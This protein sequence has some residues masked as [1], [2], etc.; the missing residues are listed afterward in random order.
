MSY[1]TIIVG[2]FPVTDTPEDVEVVSYKW[3][4]HQPYERIQLEKQYHKLKLPDKKKTTI[5][6]ALSLLERR[7]HEVKILNEILAY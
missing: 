3:W 2:H 6:K 5:V 1:R 4:N 7:K